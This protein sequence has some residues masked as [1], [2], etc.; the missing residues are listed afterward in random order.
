MK[1][2]G[3]VVVLYA[4]QYAVQDEKTNE[5]NKGTSIVYIEGEELKP[6]TNAN[7][8]KGQ[9]PVKAQLP[10]EAFSS[11]V[12]VPALYEAEF[13]PSVDSKM[14]MSLRLTALSYISSVG[15]SQKQQA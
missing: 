12:E 11:L 15:L 4:G 8:T 3:K 14:K 2:S 5:E 1:V 13:E 10:Y 6:L 7:G 9:R